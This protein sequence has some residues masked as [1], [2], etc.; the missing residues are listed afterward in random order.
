MDLAGKKVSEKM[1]TP[2]PFQLEQT[3]TRVFINVPDKKEIQVADLA[4][5][6]TVSVAHAAV[7]V[8]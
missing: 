2:N 5:G 4:T 3:G 6:K 7:S 8:R 1:R